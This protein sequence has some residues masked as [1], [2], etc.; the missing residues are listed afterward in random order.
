M[1]SIP[2]S[3]QVNDGADTLEVVQD[4]FYSST[5]PLEWFRMKVSF[6]YEKI[7]VVCQKV[8]GVNQQGALSQ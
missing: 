6:S 7:I 1:F 5:E 2:A 8:D 4:N 3:W